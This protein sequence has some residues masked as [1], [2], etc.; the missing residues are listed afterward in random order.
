MTD[1][2][3]IRAFLTSTGGVGETMRPRSGKLL[4]WVPEKSLGGK[5]FA[6]LDMAGG[7]TARPVLSLR[8]RPESYH[9]VIE[10]YGLVPAPYSARF[11]WVAVTDWSSSSR[12]VLE[13]L[14]RDAHAYTQERRPE[15]VR[16]IAVS[17]AR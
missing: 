11:H 16:R 3:D 13:A 8:V 4:Y 1:G 15:R 9:T 6:L 5:T 7:T 2:N 10:T 14:L 12:A 17:H